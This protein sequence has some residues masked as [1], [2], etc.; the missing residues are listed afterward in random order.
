M[1]KFRTGDLVAKTHPRHQ[2]PLQ[3]GL[4]INHDKETFL[5]KWTSFN[6][7]FFMEKDGDIFQELN[8]SFLLNTVQFYRNRQEPSLVLLNSSYINEP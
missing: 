3:V 5:V 4:V 1:W 8:N 6:K 7:D 2:K